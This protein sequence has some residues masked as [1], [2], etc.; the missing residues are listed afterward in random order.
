MTKLLKSFALSVAIVSL[1]FSC[2]GIQKEAQTVNRYYDVDSLITSAIAKSLPEDKVLKV[3]KEVEIDGEKESKEF[4]YDSIALENE[5]RLFRQMDINEPAF[6]FSYDEEKGE[7]MIRYQ[8]KSKEKQTGITKLSVTKNANQQVIEG[9]FSENNQIYYTSR[10]LKLRIE[11][12]MIK[13][14]E[15]AGKQK[16]ML[17][18]TIYYSMKG[19][20]I[21]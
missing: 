18:D 6:A 20:I 8:L 13:S 5:L 2:E 1:L 15:M 17:K 19:I 14:Y 12:G 4:S 3:S 21:N 10:K 7:G 11:N 16:M 9:L